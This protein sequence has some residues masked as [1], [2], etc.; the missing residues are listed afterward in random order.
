MPPWG[1][2]LDE[3]T[4]WKISTYEMSFVMGSLR[5]FSGDVSDSEGDK[6][7][8]STHITPGIEGNLKDHETGRGIFGLYCAQCHGSDGLGDGPAS[9]AADGGFIQPQPANFEESGSDFTNYGRWVWK[10]TE[11]V[12]TTNMPPWKYALSE[13]EIFQVIFYE[14]GFSKPQDYN[15]KWAPL[16]SSE[17]A[18]TLR[19]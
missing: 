2:S 14:Q 18:K 19:P 7:D 15:E 11:G 12:E 9:I 8:A 5:T 16:Y 6:F 1:W 17:Y 4:R 3:T 10:V 13:E